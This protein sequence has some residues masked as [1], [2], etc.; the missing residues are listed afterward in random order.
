MLKYSDPLSLNLVPISISWS[1]LLSH[2]KELKHNITK[3]NLNT[4]G[5]S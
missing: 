4:F 1:L 2:E 3:S 5:K